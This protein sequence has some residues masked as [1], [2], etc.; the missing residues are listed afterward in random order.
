MLARS[1]ELTQRWR[2]AENERPSRFANWPWLA[3]ASWGLAFGALSAT[4]HILSD[5][6]AEIWRDAPQ[7]LAVAFFTGGLPI[8]FWRSIEPPSAASARDTKAMFK[9][10]N[11]RARR[12]LRSS[13]R[14]DPN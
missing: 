8:Y 12:A 1:L 5:G 13:D 2:V 6:F 11:A 4:N 7:V 14:S 3:H 9:R 10:I